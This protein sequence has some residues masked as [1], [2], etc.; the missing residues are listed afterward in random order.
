M[1]EPFVGTTTITNEEYRALL[2]SNQAV[3]DCLRGKNKKINYHHVDIDNGILYC[4]PETLESIKEIE[5]LY[6]DKYQGSVDRENKALERVH[7]NYD[8][9]LK[10]I[11][12]AVAAFHIAWLTVGLFI[13]FA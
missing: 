9:K 13:K 7:R 6:E 1:S 3:M 4:D 2:K 12:I 10:K 8:A 11:I 5:D